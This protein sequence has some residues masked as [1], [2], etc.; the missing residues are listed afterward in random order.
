MA[1]VVIPLLHGRYWN[2]VGMWSLV[3]AAF[4]PVLL[5]VVVVNLYHRE[6]NTIASVVSHQHRVSRGLTKYCRH[7][8]TSERV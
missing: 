6:S 4:L 2:V 5:A 1:V 7:G 8:T 3:E